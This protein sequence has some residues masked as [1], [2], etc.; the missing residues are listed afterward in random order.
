MTDPVKRSPPSPTTPEK[1]PKGP[2]WAKLQLA[3]G[4]KP[5]RW[6][7]GVAL[8]IAIAVFLGMV[9]WLHWVRPH[10]DTVALEYGLGYGTLAACV[11]GVVLH[12]MWRDAL[13][14][15]LD[16]LRPTTPSLLFLTTLQ[17]LLVAWLFK[18]ALDL[19][20]ITSAL[21]Y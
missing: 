15:G 4:P 20:T 17:V 8:W 1:G 18:M 7:G 5:G 14:P 11:L 10:L 12:S 2:L 3:E 13:T 9:G 16:H 6:G 19:Y 21:R